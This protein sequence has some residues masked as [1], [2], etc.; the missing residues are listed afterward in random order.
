MAARQPLPRERHA[1]IGIG[2]KLYVW[3]GLSSNPTLRSRGLEVFDVPSISWKEPRLL[4]GSSIPDRLW[5]MAVTSDGD[6]AYF[7]GGATGSH[8]NYTRCNTL[9]RL[10]P[11]QH[12]SQV[13]EIQHTSPADTTPQK[14]QGSR[15]VQHKDKLV[16]LGGRTGQG[17]TNE[18]H[19]FDLKKSECERWY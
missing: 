18:L 5:D 14:K 17:R 8:P 16:L 1:A 10:T 9:Y 13:Q 4:R 15:I 2:S 19:V 6:T 11:S 3:G 7:F 12:L